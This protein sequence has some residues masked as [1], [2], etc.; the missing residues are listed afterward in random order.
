MMFND[1]TSNWGHKLNILNPFHSS[2]SIGI[3]YDEN[4]V[5]LVQDFEDPTSYPVDDTY[6]FEYHANVQTHNSKHCW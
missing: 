1:S 6:L 3:A 2:V 4:S 5:V